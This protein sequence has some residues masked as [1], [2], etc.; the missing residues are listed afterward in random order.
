VAVIH[1][2][3]PADDVQRFLEDVGWA[4]VADDEFTLEEVAGSELS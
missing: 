1:P 3:V 2:I 4:G